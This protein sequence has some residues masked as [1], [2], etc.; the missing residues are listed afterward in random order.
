[1]RRFQD[2]PGVGSRYLLLFFGFGVLA[3]VKGI[4]LKVSLLWAWILRYGS[5]H[6]SVAVNVA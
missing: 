1:M 2:P 4:E 5:K 6:Y 3:F